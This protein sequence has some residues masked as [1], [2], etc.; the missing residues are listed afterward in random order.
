MKCGSISK[1]I[2][3]AEFAQQKGLGVVLGNGV[4]T[5]I[6]CYLE[7]LIQNKLNLKVAGEMN[8]FNKQADSILGE[9]LTQNKAGITIRK[10]FKPVISNVA[11]GRLMREAVSYQ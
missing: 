4:Q 11:L 5:E 9:S 6:G 3:Y 8:G 1:T 7:A 2:E 10:D